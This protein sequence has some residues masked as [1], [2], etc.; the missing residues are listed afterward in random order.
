VLSGVER[1]GR[2]ARLSGFEPTIVQTEKRREAT[3]T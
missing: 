2:A 1:E 3:P